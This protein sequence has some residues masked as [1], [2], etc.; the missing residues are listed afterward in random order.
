MKASLYYFLFILLIFSSC[1][2][3]DDNKIVSA[4]IYDSDYIYHEFSPPL[5]VD[6][7]LD[8]IKDDYFWNDSIDINQDGIYELFIS[9]RIHIPAESGSPTFDHFPYLRLITKSDLQI[10]RKIDYYAVGHGQVNEID[11]V[12]TLN[13]KTQI[14]DNNDW[15]E[16]NDILSIWLVPPLGA[17]GT[18]P[19]GTWFNLTNE[20]KYVGIRMK[21]G[22]RYK[23]G[24]IKLNVI[25]RDDIQFICYAI[26]K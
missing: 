24:W 3:D 9:Q 15:T 4:G 10:A 21:I 19:Y 2:K 23:Y 16:G 11:W 1:L 7:K 17:P 5:K 8:T 14:N 25:S 13:Y 22:K 18:L 26:E 20:E 6:L 12:D